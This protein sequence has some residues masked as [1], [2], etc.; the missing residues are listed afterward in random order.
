MNLRRFNTTRP[1]LPV[2]PTDP[3]A[4]FFVH[5]TKHHEKIN[6]P[7]RTSRSETRIPRF[8][9]CAITT[10]S[11]STRALPSS[12]SL[13]I[14]NHKRE[15]LVAFPIPIVRNSKRIEDVFLREPDINE[16]VNIEKVSATHNFHF[17]VHTLRQSRSDPGVQ[18]SLP[19]PVYPKQ[20][21]IAQGSYVRAVS[22]KFVPVQGILH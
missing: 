8:G 18:P 12:P 19:K 1:R 14:C 17:P 10:S 22:R 2:A 13:T 9:R 6:G 15:R 11:D 7:S 21:R 3:F 4:I 5:F 16:N 20:R